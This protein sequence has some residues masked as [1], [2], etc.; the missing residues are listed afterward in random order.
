VC[1]EVSYDSTTRIALARIAV[2]AAASPVVVDGDSV[3]QVQVTFRA[4]PKQ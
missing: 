2:D 3:K 4:G 1:K